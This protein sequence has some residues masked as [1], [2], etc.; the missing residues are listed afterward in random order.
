MLQT[1]Q[2]DQIVFT[3]CVNI[4]HTGVYKGGTSIL[5]IRMLLKFDACHRQFWGFDSFEGLPVSVAQ[6]FSGHLSKG[7][8]G[9]Y[10]ASES[11]IYNNLKKFHA[12]N[13]DIVH[14]TKGF[15][16]ETLPVSPIPSIAFLRLD[17]DV[18]TSTWDALE[19]LYP[20]VV[21]GGYI[22]ID[23]YDSFNG[24]KAAVDLYRVEKE[25]SEPLIRI[26]EGK[27]PSQR[28]KREY[29]AVWWQKRLD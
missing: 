3:L 1:Q 4:S 12:H 21:P 8:K 10:S 15:F 9:Q 6:D 13:T 20:K 18:F 22:Y 14:I 27:R 11:V 17:G 7:S 24:C 28:M 19:H 23:D 26:L 2:A 5:L 25:V 16:N 29:E